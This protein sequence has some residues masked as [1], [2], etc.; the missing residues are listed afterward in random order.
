MVAFP[1]PIVISEC[2]RGLVPAHVND[3]RPYQWFATMSM[4]CD[5]LPSSTSFTTCDHSSPDCSSSPS[6]PS[7]LAIIFY[8]NTI[9][10]T[11]ATGLFNVYKKKNVTNHRFLPRLAPK[12]WIAKKC[13]R[14]QDNWGKKYTAA[15]YHY[16]LFISS[17]IL[18]PETS[19]DQLQT[20]NLREVYV[21][22]CV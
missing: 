15:S 16:W 9:V 1:N 8:L 13:S 12:L 3:L 7:S 4:I 10:Q 6:T 20:K 14:W 19:C 11:F 18:I 5:H 2:Y 21:H 17:K 22:F